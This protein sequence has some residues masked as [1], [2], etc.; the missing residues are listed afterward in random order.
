MMGGDAR[1]YTDEMGW[2]AVLAPR[3]S[4]TEI[5]QSATQ[6]NNIFFW[7]DKPRHFATFVQAI[8]DKPLLRESLLIAEFQSEKK[9]IIGQHLLSPETRQR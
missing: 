7:S 3:C 4:V 9:R 2:F 8:P 5:R 6:F 1:T